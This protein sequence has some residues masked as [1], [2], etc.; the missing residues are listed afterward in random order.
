MVTDRSEHLFR[1]H[2]RHAHGD[3]V[4]CGRLVTSLLLDAMTFQPPIDG[5]DAARVRRHELLDIRLR[6]ML[7]VTRV[8]RIADLRKVLLE[9]GE[10]QLGKSDAQRND[11]SAWRAP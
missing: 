7:S 8:G 11:V 3:P 1:L 6:Q 2:N 9:L 5:V 10:A 4:A